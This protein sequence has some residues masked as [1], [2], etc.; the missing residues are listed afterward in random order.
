MKRLKARGLT[1][2]SVK[3]AQGLFA[4]SGKSDKRNQVT[5]IAVTKLREKQ[6]REKNKK[7]GL[8]KDVEI[9][10]LK[11]LGLTG[12]VKTEEVMAF[13]QNFH[14][15]K[16]A[17]FNNVR[18]LTTILENT[19]NP[20]L[21]DIIADILNGI[22]AGEY[23]YTTMEHYP[24]VF[25]M[26]Y[27]S[28]I[29]VGEMSDSLAESL[30]QALSSLE[31]SKTMKRQ[32]KKA[33]TQPIIM[34]GAL[35]IMTIVAIVWGLP[36]MENLYKE[37]GVEDVKG[38]K[39]ALEKYQKYLDSQKSD[40]EKANENLNETQAKLTSAET[41]ANKA[42]FCLK[43]IAEFEANPKSVDDLVAIAMTKVT[44]D[45]DISTV[46]KEM[47]ENEAYNGF[48]TKSGLSSG[49]SGTGNPLPKGKSNNNG[50]ESYGARLAQQKLARNNFN[51]N[52]S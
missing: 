47:K 31:D 25:P 21:Q 44:D 29:K 33:V 20:A 49:S 32:V 46:L 36:V 5:A 15:L 13:T 9:P 39:E 42:E 28:I 2:I 8:K 14:L 7:K 11:N 35:I 19:E 40:L 3:K 50:S 38:T 26:L 4:N 43:A 34:I 27:V 48:F 6:E 52:K 17:G 30:S 41:R 37:L 10:F 1:P 45:K 23:I 51:K 22:E 12:T 24:K 18:A 16:R